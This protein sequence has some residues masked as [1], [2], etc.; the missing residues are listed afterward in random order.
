MGLD[1]LDGS[2]FEKEEENE[3]EGVAAETP[4]PGQPTDAAPE[5][6]LEEIES[7]G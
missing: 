7:E 1:L 6:E 5:D 3:A 2:V 4:D